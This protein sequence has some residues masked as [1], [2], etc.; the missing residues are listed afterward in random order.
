MS[1]LRVLALSLWLGVSVLFWGFVAAS[2]YLGSGMAP[3]NVT[4][5]IIAALVLAIAFLGWAQLTWLIG[6]RLKRRAV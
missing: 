2:V 6:K 3:P 1:P 4:F 5:D